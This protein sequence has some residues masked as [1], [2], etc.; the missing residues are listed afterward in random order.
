[1]A[2]LARTERAA[3]DHGGTTRTNRLRVKP[4]Q[5]PL[6]LGGPRSMSLAMGSDRNA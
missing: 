1:M 3:P 5:Y 2:R 6:A 4:A